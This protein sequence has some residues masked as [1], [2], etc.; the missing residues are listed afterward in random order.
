VIRV[1]NTLG[2]KFE[3]FSTVENGIVKMYVC[4]PTVYDYV[5][6]GHGRTFV[7]Y[8]AIVRYL[9]LK[10]Y[11]VIRI[12]NITDI[13]DKIINRAK[14]TGK[15]WEEIVDYYSKDYLEN[16]SLLKV[17]IDLHPRVTQHIKEIINFVQ[18]LI[19]KGHAYVAPSGSVYFDVD[20]YPHYGELSN[21]KKDQWNQ[22]EEFVKEKRHPYDFALWKAWKPGEPYWDSPWGKGRP[23][24]HIECSTMSTRYLGEQ[25]DIH[26]GGMDLIFPHHENERA[27]TESLTGKP[28]VR[29]WMHVAFLNI[30]GE[31]MSKSLGN[32]VTLKDALKKYGADVL[33]YWYLSSHYRSPIDFSEENLEQSKASLQRL[34]D[35]VAVLKDILKEGPKSYSKD[36]DIKVKREIIQ[37]IREFD[38][39]MSNDFDTATALKKIHDIANIVF[40]KLQNSRD[41]LGASIALD[42]FRIFNEVFGVMDEEMGLAYERIYEVIDGII[43]V[44]NLLRQ[45]K[46]YDLTDQIRSILEAH[47][48]KVLDTKD[49]STW[50]FQ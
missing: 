13:D 27:Q 16:L 22:G 26:G 3:D 9:R 33:R 32:I 25:F 24:W 19:D 15:S 12:Q 1:F 46:M 40:S 38:E 42:G 29:Y 47:G 43:E 31:K 21:T 5:H 6:I 41:F 10:G 14:E 2:R 28:W 48:I 34:K 49:K 8:D 35:A 50:R 20:T 4:G 11:N 30:R 36:E 18:G 37:K 17:K 44:R 23:G 7:A 39:A 45:K